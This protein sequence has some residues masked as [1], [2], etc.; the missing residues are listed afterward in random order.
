MIEALTV[1]VGEL[2]QELEVTHV[3]YQKLLEKVSDSKYVAGPI[4]T[5]AGDS[6]GPGTATGGAAGGGGG[7][8]PTTFGRGS[9]GPP[10]SVPN[11]RSS[12]NLGGGTGRRD[13][14]D[15]EIPSGSLRGGEM[16]LSPDDR[17][18]SRIAPDFDMVRPPGQ[19]VY[20][21]SSLALVQAEF[22]VKANAF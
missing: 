13:G 10:G 21:I 4:E 16:M 2:K 18:G 22:W 12:K 19:I 6:G 1:R 3:H 11:S 7:R 15:S 8:A 9:G 5:A 17:H 14:F 20:L